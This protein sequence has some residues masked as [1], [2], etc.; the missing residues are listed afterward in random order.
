MNFEHFLQRGSI[1]LL[2]IAIAI[3]GIRDSWYI[4]DIEFLLVVLGGV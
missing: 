4:I 2:I 3:I 1:V